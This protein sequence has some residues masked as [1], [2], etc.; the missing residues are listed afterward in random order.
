MQTRDMGVPPK[1]WS[2]N[3]ETIV[4][5]PEDFDAVNI[6]LSLDLELRIVAE[7]I[8]RAR[9]IGLAYP[10]ERTESLRA[11]LDKGRVFKAGGHQITAKDLDRFIVQADFPI[12]HEGE[13]ATVVYVALHRGREWQRLSNQ[14][15]AFDEKSE[16]IDDLGRGAA[17]MSASFV[18]IAPGTWS[19]VSNQPVPFGFI[20]VWNGPGPGGRIA[21]VRWRR[22]FSTP[23]F[24][25]DG[26][27]TL[28]PGKNT[29]ITPP[30]L[31]NAWYFN[32]A[33]GVPLTTMLT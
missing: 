12:T 6:A 7:A 3:A 31:I 33:D 9:K 28:S 15:T 29:W 26:T 17:T 10:V 16:S 27:A 22:H 32:P 13:L 20:Y 14:L 25:L 11:L 23:P 24:Y 30:S 2:G 18:T 21:T 5:S 4:F 8:V 1:G 19:Y